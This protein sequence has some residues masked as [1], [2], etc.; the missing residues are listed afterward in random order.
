MRETEALF[1]HLVSE[2]QQ[3]SCPVPGNTLSTA[4][5]SAPS[6]PP[7]SLPR[8][9][10]AFSPVFV[11]QSGSTFYH[12]SPNSLSVLDPVPYTVSIK[13]HFSD[14]RVCFRRPTK[15]APFES[16]AVRVQVFDGDFP[17]QRPGSS[18]CRWAEHTTSLCFSVVCQKWR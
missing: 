8:P 9:G 11:Y 14:A 15:L 17:V 16:Q 2:H 3:G 18:V 5:G 4:E 6:P 1:V 10:H 7:P 13:S 12:I